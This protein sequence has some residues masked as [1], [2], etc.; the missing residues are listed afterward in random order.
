V[1]AQAEH[2]VALTTHYEL[3]QCVFAKAIVPVHEENKVC[4]WL[5]AN[6][7]LEYPRE[8]VTGPL[9]TA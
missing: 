3:S 5:G 7:M 9:S 8:E 4:L 1:R 2:G 6:V